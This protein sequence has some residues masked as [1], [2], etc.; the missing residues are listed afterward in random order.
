V[1]RLRRLLPLAAA[2]AAV[3]PPAAAAAEEVRIFRDPAGVPHVEAPTFLGVAYGT[4]YAL[5]LDRP[6][7]LSAIRVTAQGRS[8]ELLGAGSLAADVVQRRDFYDE[9]DAR[10]QLEALSPER[11]RELQAFADGVNAGWAEVRADP[12]QRPVLW[13]GFGYDPPPWTPLDSIAVTSLFTYSTFAGEGG[14]GQLRNAA[15]LARLEAR[16]GA[17]RGLRMWDDLLWKNDPRAPSVIPRGEGTPPRASVVRERPGARQLALA[18]ELGPLLGRVAERRA[19]EA[20]RVARALERLPIPRIG[21]YALAVA[22]S[23]TRSGGAVTLGSPQAGFTAPPVFWQVGQHSPG[24]DC[25]GFTVPGLGP[26]MGVGWCN[27]HAWSLVAGNA[28]E[29]VDHHVERVEA[30]D[31]RAYRFEGARR[32]MQVRREVFKVNGCPP[33]LCPSAVDREEVREFESTVHGPVVDRLPSRR[34]AITQRR[35]QRGIWARSLEA[36]ARWNT[37]RSL[38]EF[39]RAT[40]LANGTYNVV[41]GDAAGRILYRFSGVQP[42][43]AR[44]IDRRL[45]TPGEGGAEWRGLLPQSAM[46][47]V[48]DPRSGILVANQGIESKPAPW[49]PSS[50]SVALG[51]ASRVALNRRQLAAA[52]PVDADRLE[53]L[54]RD[55]FEGRDPMTPLFERELRAA[56]RGSAEPRLQTALRVL[57][58]WARGGFRRD[59]ADLDGDY[60]DPGI[61]LFGADVL[62]GLPTTRPVWRTLQDLVFGDE[63]GE[64]PEGAPEAEGGTF[65]APGTGLGRLSTLKLALERS[66]RR[67][68]RASDPRVLRLQTDFVDDVRTPRRERAPELIRE[69][70]RRAM[71]QLE[72][73]FGTPDVGRWQ[74]RKAVL[75]FAALGVVAPP[76]LTRS[77]DHG[78]YSQIV[79]PRSGDG[80]FILPPGNV[81]ADS[82]PRI[83]A[84]QAGSP[85]PGFDDQRERYERYGYLPMRQGD[86][87]YRRDA[88][89]VRCCRRRRAD[90]IAAREHP[91][92]L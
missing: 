81:A 44:G 48:V 40:D 24:R 69:A 33:P 30:D 73:Q 4:G 23:R 18:R 10:R 43:R 75:P 79:D 47:R 64:A 70:V 86:A 88:V 41:Y 66:A 61:A 17:R 26:Y 50:S 60:D 46:P 82:A 15:L 52:T 90:T 87:A 6:F 74:V 57:D 21:S 35:A 92:G 62:G 9:A 77:Y 78:T 29:Q 36:V 37:A 42:V 27:G 84:A 16:H 71:A 45:P 85:P 20:R 13:D 3:L 80:R 5:A 32:R 83:A 54:H 67:R 65:Q 38:E 25:T 59:D 1:S 7:L 2:L 49:W 55:L 76:P 58:S 22:G 91:S 14:A 19:A 68:A 11:R 12:L 34:L 89:D 8:A 39:D 53:A 56:L 72:A 63:L 31:E 28:G 51:R